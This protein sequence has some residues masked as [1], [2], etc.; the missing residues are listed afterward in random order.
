MRETFGKFFSTLWNTFLFQHQYA[1]LDHWT[2]AQALP[3]QDW[4]DLDRWLLSRLNSAV[5]EAKF[6]AD[7]YHLHKATRAIEAFV[8]D[9]LSNW[10]VRRSRDRFWGERA[11]RDKQ[12]AHS[13]LW[14]ALHTVCRL[15]APFAPFMVEHIWAH[16]RTA[17]DKDSVHLAPWPVAGKRDEELEREMTQVRALA[18]AGRALRSKVNIPTRHP[19]GRAVLVGTALGRFAPILQDE[20]NV[21]QLESAHDTKALKSF[22]AKPNRSALGKAFKALGT[23]IA[24]AIEGLDGDQAKAL[25]EAGKPVGVSVG[26]H[27]HALTADHLVFEEKD[28]PGW[29]TTKVEDVVLALHVERNEELLAEALVREVIRRIQEARRDLDL[30]LDEEID[31]VLEC[32]PNEEARL[33]RFQHVIKADVRGRHVSFGKAGSGGRAWDID[34]VAVTATM[35]PTKT[36]RPP[37]AEAA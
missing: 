32:G 17:G 25:V 23:Q 3:Q 8:V 37:A 35:I 21:K 20:I 28:R 36:T 5:A 14:T 9:D 4:T 18:E 1:K 6:E 16:L 24:D 10:W 2:P 15:V 27:D 26:G 22:V 33:S 13:A 34:G 12:S 11:S 30:P 29:A 19:L 7:R 31:V